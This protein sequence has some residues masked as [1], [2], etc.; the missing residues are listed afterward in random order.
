MNRFA[1]GAWQTFSEAEQA[2]ECLGSTT[3][4]HTAEEM[5]PAYDGW[6]QAVQNLM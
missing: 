5:A 6:K 3:P 2:W 1:L 4:A